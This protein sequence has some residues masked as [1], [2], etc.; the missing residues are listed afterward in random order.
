MKTHEDMSVNELLHALA[1][2][3]LTSGRL[4]VIILR[5]GWRDILW[6]V[7]TLAA[8]A[9]CLA[10]LAG[11]LNLQSAPGGPLK[12][13]VWGAELSSPFRLQYL[14]ILAALTIIFLLRRNLWR[15]LGTGLFA[16]VNL[17]VLLPF[18]F[19]PAPAS[20][21]VAGFRAFMLNVGNNNRSE[22]AVIDL[23]RSA[24]PDIVLLV[25]A[26]LTRRDS[27]QPLEE[28]YPY[29]TYSPGRE[30]YDGALLY[31]KYPFTSETVRSSGARKQNSLVAKIQLG[32]EELTL[33]GVQ[34][35]APLRPGR[36]STL[37]T[38]LQ[39]MAQLVS[40][41]DGPTLLM[42]DLNTTPWAPIF[43]DFLRSAGMRDSRRGFGLQI[44]W[45]T[46]LPPL[47]IPIDHALVSPDITVRHLE[48]GPN[49]GSDHYPVILDFTLGAAKTEDKSASAETAR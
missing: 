18:L 27:F 49:V 38:Q 33:L 34:T 31:S 13:I 20:Q 14:A 9:L 3:I 17:A 30:S 21:Q 11:F 43:Q 23:V 42:G 25:E 5:R 29:V 37:R 32:S 28:Y 19:A 47:S 10:T 24:D 44:T 45:P 40:Q 39:E 36:S 6:G 7:L 22:Q 16:L 8:V 1:A 4:T 46:Y 48:V 35:R 26:G 41:Q 2:S 15:A 12:W